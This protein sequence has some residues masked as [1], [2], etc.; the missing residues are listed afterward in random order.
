MLT[1]AIRKSHETGKE[2]FYSIIALED[3]HRLRVRYTAHFTEG[4]VP[5]FLMKFVVA[6]TCE[7]SIFRTGGICLNRLRLRKTY[8]ALMFDRNSPF[9]RVLLSLSINSSMASTGESGFSTFRNTQMRVK[10][11]L[12]M[13]SSSL[14]VPER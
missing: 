13:S 11:S 4:N 6:H 1:Y 7:C 10:S 12:G 9:V 3:S 14:R 2:I 5:Q 8:R